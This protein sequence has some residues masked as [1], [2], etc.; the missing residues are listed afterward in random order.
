MVKDFKIKPP[1]RRTTSK[2]KFSS[3]RKRKQQNRDVLGLPIAHS[4]PQ[5]Q[6]ERCFESTLAHTPIISPFTKSKNVKVTLTPSL[7]EE[8]SHASKQRPSR[9]SMRPQKPKIQ[10]IDCSANHIKIQHSPIRTKQIK[11][12]VWSTP[13]VSL[14]S[15]LTQ[16]AEDDGHEQHLS[17]NQASVLRLFMSDWFKAFEKEKGNY[18]SLGM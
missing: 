7:H 13:Q 1:P 11:K 5:G 18:N 16:F 15:T 17:T 14:H 4:V 12:H 9:Q 8:T 10:Y 2:P 6:R 3:P